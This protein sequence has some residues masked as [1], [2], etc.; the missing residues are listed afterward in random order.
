MVRFSFTSAAVPCDAN[1]PSGSTRSFW[2]S[3]TKSTV[4]EVSISSMTDP[5]SFRRRSRRPPLYITAQAS[6]LRDGEAGYQGSGCS[7]SDTRP[8]DPDCCLGGI[9]TQRRGVVL[10]RKRDTEPAS[11]LTRRLHRLIDKEKRRLR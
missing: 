7:A 4:L 9:G 5:L 1:A 8:V 10:S 11:G 2:K 6:F 3:M